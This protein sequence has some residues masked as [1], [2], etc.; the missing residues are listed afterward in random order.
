MVSNY[1]PEKNQTTI[2]KGNIRIIAR[3]SLSFSLVLNDS[4][5]YIAAVC[6]YIFY[7]F[8]GYQIVLKKSSTDPLTYTII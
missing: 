8:V 1:S 7:Q 6:I 2:T 3:L 4:S 5:T